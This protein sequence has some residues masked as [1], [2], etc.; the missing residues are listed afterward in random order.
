MSISLLGLG[1]CEG[2]DM[3]LLF[4]S[5][6]YFGRLHFVGCLCQLPH[7][8]PSMDIYTG[9]PTLP[10]LPG[11][12]VCSWL[13]IWLVV[14]QIV[15]RML[16]PFVALTLLGVYDFYSSLSM[17][18]LLVTSIAGVD[19]TSNLWLQFWLIRA[20]RQNIARIKII[21]W[22]HRVWLFWFLIIQKHNVGVVHAF[23]Y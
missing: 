7:C 11:I 23:S 13:C 1:L 22:S 18:M 17:T 21:E 9:Y 20:I 6:G 4:R 2:I 19:L 12:G 14:D 15:F 5:V 3:G 16:V 8:L 10:L